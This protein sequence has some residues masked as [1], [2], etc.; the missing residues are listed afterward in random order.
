[1]W[2]FYGR[3]NAIKQGY[4]MSDKQWKRIRKAVNPYLD[5][6]D[7]NVRAGMRIP[8]HIRIVGFF[9]KKVR[10]NYIRQW[11]R[12]HKR[13]LKKAMKYASHLVKENIK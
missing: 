6:M 10:T 9:F 2:R 8:L 11:E 13:A 4:G 12:S 7:L 1:M 3:N 5:K